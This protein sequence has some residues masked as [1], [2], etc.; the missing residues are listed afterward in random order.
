MTQRNYATKFFNF[1]D[2]DDR[3]TNLLT[4]LLTSLVTY[5]PTYLFT[6]ILIYLLTYINY[7]LTP[8]KIVLLE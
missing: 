7:L 6:S 3:S 8:C 1:M 2:F 4:Y 5:L